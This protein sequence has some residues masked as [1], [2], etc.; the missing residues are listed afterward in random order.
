MVFKNVFF[1]GLHLDLEGDME[2]V[3]TKSKLRM[4]ASTKDGVFEASFYSNEGIKKGELSGNYTDE[5]FYRDNATGKTISI[6]K[7]KQ[8]LSN[9]Y[10]QY[11]YNLFAIQ[12]N[13][14]TD[15][16]KNYI[17]P[18]DSRYRGDIRN[19]EEGQMEKAEVEK[20]KI[21]VRQRLVRKR[22]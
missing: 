14:L 16:M 6:W 18:T 12:M 5:L 21:E 17:A 15:E 8:P 10:Y 20:C 22:I 2:G 3:S 13:H 9:A 7:A 4:K 11:Q 1:G 19:Y